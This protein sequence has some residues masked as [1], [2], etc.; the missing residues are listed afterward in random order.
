MSNTIQRSQREVLRHF[1]TASRS[2]GDASPYQSSDGLSTAAAEDF[3]SKR[4]AMELIGDRH[5]VADATEPT[6]AAVQDWIEQC[7]RQVALPLNF[8]GGLLIQRL[9]RIIAPPEEQNTDWIKVVHDAAAAYDFAFLALGHA[10]DEADRTTVRDGKPTRFVTHPHTIAVDGIN[11]LLSGVTAMQEVLGRWPVIDAEGS[12][13][14]RLGQHPLTNEIIGE[15]L[16]ALREASFPIL[17]D[18]SGAGHSSSGEPLDSGLMP[19]NVDADSLRRVEDF[20]RH[21]AHTYFMR[22]TTLAVL[23]AGYKTIDPDFLGALQR[24]FHS[25]SVLGAATDDLQDIFTDFDAGIHS[26][27]TVLA[28][29][30]VSGDPS[31]RP[32]FRKNVPEATLA[33][34]RVRLK[35]FFGNSDTRASAEDFLDFL[36]EIELR[37]AIT[38]YLEDHGISLA[39]AVHDAIVRFNFRPEIMSDIVSVVC[40]DPGFS[41][42]STYLEFVKAADDPQILHAMNAHAGKLITNY[43]LERFWPDGPC[44]S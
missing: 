36:D 39:E 11:L 4:L 28:H 23:L 33:D 19:I 13:S 15:L 34:Q 10:D 1:T 25:W 42:P 44:S 21:R 24:L 16:R 37:K 40:R 12:T 14:S 2:L 20:S 29:L 6:F 26:S 18:R 5:F 43:L 30:C 35:V 9:Y 41:L 31:L 8:C 27:S 32:S 7:E 22:A 3:E 38:L 17:L